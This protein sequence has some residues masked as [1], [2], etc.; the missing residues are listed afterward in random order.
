V[1]YALHTTA[2]PALI[3]SLTLFFNGNWT[4]LDA[5]DALKAAIWNGTAW[6]DI[7][8]DLLADGAFSPAA[9]AKNYVDTNGNIWIMF[10]DS[11]SI[12]NE[13]KDILT[14]D[15]LSVRITVGPPDT[16]APSAPVGVAA[17]AAGLTVALTWNANSEADLAGYRVYRSATP[18]SGYELVTA[19]LVTGATYNDTTPAAGAYYYVITAV[20]QSGNESIPSQEVNVTTTQ[21]LY[22]VH[23]ENIAM[24][25]E[26]LNKNSRAIASVLIHHQ[27]EAAQAGATVV[28]DWYFKGSLVESGA[29]GVT[30]AD[31]V[32]VISS[33]LYPAKSG[34]IFTF[35][36]TNAL[37]GG[38][39]YDQSKN[40]MSENSIAAP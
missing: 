15:Y 9:N 17:A 27:G 24:A 26:K 34:N 16:Q 30:G 8:A 37:L 23:V 10:T 32:A 14:V 33:A 36:I 35:K 2:T 38:Y 40:V 11:V 18:G 12:R 21:P 13:K 3:T 5:T 7:T 29:T 22:A 25:L 6:E 20:D 31:G 19:Q 28:G 39:S 1:Q 4:Q